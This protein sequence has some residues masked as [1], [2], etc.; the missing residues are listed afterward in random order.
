M[1]ASTGALIGTLFGG[2]GLKAIEYWIKRRRAHRA[3]TSTVEVTRIESALN[4]DKELW[5]ILRAELSEA[6]AAEDA[7]YKKLEAA[8][9]RMTV[10]QVELLTF[11]LRHGEPLTAAERTFLGINGEDSSLKDKH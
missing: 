9:H 4:K 6:R 11:K 7:A 8:E 5:L 2:A 10:C 3:A 1:D